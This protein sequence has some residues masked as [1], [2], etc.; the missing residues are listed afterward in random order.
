MPTSAPV[1]TPV[2]T[3]TT[4]PDANPLWETFTDPGKIC[5]QQRRE[6]ASPDVMP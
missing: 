6:T 3:P 1:T 5:D 2:I 4:N